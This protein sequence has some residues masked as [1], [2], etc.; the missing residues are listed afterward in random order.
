MFF[1]LNCQQ[2]LLKTSLW[3]YE[4]SYSLRVRGLATRKMLVLRG[5]PYTEGDFAGRYKQTRIM[6]VW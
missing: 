4:S 6:T 5:S 2:L 1:L 3:L